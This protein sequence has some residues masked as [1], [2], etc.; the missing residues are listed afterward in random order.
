MSILHYDDSVESVPPEYPVLEVLEEAG[1]AVFRKG[2]G[3]EAIYLNM[4]VEGVR[5]S[6]N[7][8]GH[9]NPDPLSFFLQAYGENLLLDPGY[10]KWEERKK[11]ATADNHNM[12]TVDGNQP[13]LLLFSSP[14][15]GFVEVVD[16]GTYNDVTPRVE[17]TT[18]FRGAT[19]N[20]TIEYVNETSFFI[21][22]RITSEKE[23]TFTL[24]LHGHAGG[25]CGGT[26]DMQDGEMDVDK[27]A[28]WERE[29]AGVKCFISCL[30]GDA[31]YVVEEDEHSFAYNEW[32]THSCV[33]V[34]ATGRDVEFLTIVIPYKVEEKTPPQPSP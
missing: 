19:I 8:A 24:N 32:T 27:I 10:I 20:R 31:D 5:A 15:E 30:S 33:R 22:D 21:H 12:I 2:D 14:L 29:R 1:D 34:S 28:V 16:W 11:V 6:F 9:D 23:K 7:A 4:R 26:F 13:R 18:T 25:E 3:P 17:A